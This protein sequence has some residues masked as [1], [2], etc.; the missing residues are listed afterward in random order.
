MGRRDSI[1]YV[2]NEMSIRNNNADKQFR[3]LVTSSFPGCYNLLSAF[4]LKSSVGE[5]EDLAITL[6]NMQMYS[7]DFASL[8]LLLS[9]YR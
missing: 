1:I 6:I 4:N 3:F 9:R 2:V 7:S 8:C 5:K